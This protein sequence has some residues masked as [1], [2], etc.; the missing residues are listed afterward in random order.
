MI[1]DKIIMASKKQP[2]LSMSTLYWRMK[3]YGTPYKPRDG[4]TKYIIDGRPAVELA[5]ENGISYDRFYNRLKAGWTS[6]RAATQPL[7]AKR[8]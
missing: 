3:R 1:K 8:K 6:H 5:M 2:N 4:R 7:R